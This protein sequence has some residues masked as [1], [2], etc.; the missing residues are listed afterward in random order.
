MFARN[1]ESVREELEMWISIFR[2]ILIIKQGSEEWVNNL[3]ELNILKINASKANSSKLI[4]D[5]K[6]IDI[7]WSQ[8]SQ[9]VNARLC[10][11]NLMLNIT[12]FN[13]NPINNFTKVTS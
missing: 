1:R 7:A 13:E 8:L 9:N 10:L 3:S 2:D 12:S 6:Q 4:D 5:L 11:E